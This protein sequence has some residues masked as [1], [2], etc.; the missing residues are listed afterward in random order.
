MQVRRSTKFKKDVRRMQRRG[1]DLDKL[2]IVVNLLL[3]D[4]ELPDS[5]RDHELA[6]NLK[7]MRDLH[8][9]PDWLLLY[10]K[11]EPELRLFRTGTHSDLFQAVYQANFAGSEIREP[12]LQGMSGLGAWLAGFPAVRAPR[13]LAFET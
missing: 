13:R 2:K 6:G 7:G 11:T 8:I 3:T 10:E 5:L 12:F 1:N 4:A 9:E